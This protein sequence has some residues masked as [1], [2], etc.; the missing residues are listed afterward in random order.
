[1]N[2]GK[3]NFLLENNLVYIKKKVAILCKVLKNKLSTNIKN[4]KKITFFLKIYLKYLAS[5]ILLSIKH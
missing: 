3:S 1:M 4:S 2:I 5:I